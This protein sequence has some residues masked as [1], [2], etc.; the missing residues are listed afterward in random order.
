MPEMLVLAL[1]VATLATAAATPAAAVESGRRRRFPL[2]LAIGN[3]LL[4]A[5]GAGRLLYMIRL[6][7]AIFLGEARKTGKGRLFWPIFE[8]H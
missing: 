3:R 1:A 5:V 7:L 6:W 2:P 4:P 8:P